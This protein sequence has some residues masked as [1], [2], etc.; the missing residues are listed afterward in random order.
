MSPYLAIAL[1]GALGAVSRYALAEGIQKL[2][3]AEFPIGTVSVNV[4]G[5]FA[6]GALAA[7]LA[8][9]ERVPEAVQ[10]GLVVGFLGGFTTFSAFAYQT[11]ALASERLFGLALANVLVSNAV[12]LLAAWVGYR[13]V[14]LIV[15]P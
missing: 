14:S 12:G 10:L 9:D 7:W 4:A 15:D 13:L 2:A 6:I 1:G 5:C 8:G 3:Q 11:F